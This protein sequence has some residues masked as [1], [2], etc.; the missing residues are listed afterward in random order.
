MKTKNLILIPALVLCISLLCSCGSFSVDLPF[1]LPFLSGETETAET[2]PKET[3]SV[4]VVTPPKDV[5][6]ASESEYTYEELMEDAS[7][8][9]EYYSDK[10]KSKVIGT[11]LDGRDIIALTLGN[12]NAKK[13]ILITAGIHAREY[14]TP[15]L[16][17]A[18]V[19]YYLNSYE[20]ESYEGIP[21]SE[22][23]DEYAFC[24]IPMCNPD[25]ISL[26][27]LGLDGIRSEALRDTVLSVYEK[28][29][30]SGFVNGSL[31]DYLATWKANARGV[32]INRNFDT[33]D[34]GTYPIMSR[35]CF[36]NYP[37][38]KPESEPE[39]RAIAGYIKGLDK[40]VLSLAIHSQGEVIYFNCGQDN[41]SEAHALATKVSQF[42][43]YK[44]ETEE[45]HNS[46]L[47]DWCN[48]A[49]GIPS[50]TIETGS[51][52]CPLPISEFDK[53]WQ[54]NRDLFLFAAVYDMNIKG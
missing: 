13:Q 8:L 4:P 43:G 21:L 24:I 15:L 19:E 54:T 36:M 31:D 27:Q 48:K 37:G 32:D 11:S 20:T 49:L 47:D 45:H 42:T 5:V 16:V 9:A 30:L 18:Q 40:L 51:R 29:K 26:S 38:E 1:D 34:F 28:D 10:L 35:P 3:D 7:I 39:T 2:P 44:L 6:D 14:M 33:D 22:I 46:A 53:I 41:Y 23:F 25:G 12:P 50:V 52:P 17:M